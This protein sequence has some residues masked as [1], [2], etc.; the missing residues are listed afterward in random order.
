MF[1]YMYTFFY[2]DRSPRRSPRRVSGKV[3]MDELRGAVEK[4]DNDNKKKRRYDDLSR[5]PDG[6]VYIYV[7]IYICIYIRM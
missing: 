6:K 2:I 7:Y 3:P 5:K 4:N 1:I